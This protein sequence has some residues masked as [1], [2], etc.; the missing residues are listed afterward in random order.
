MDVAEEIPENVA[1]VHF[2]VVQFEVVEELF[3]VANHFMMERFVG[4]HVV[5]NIQSNEAILLQNLKVYRV[6][7]GILGV[8]K[9]MP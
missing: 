9:G 8:E 6:A 5:Y 3:S 4:G 7:L 1:Y 2:V